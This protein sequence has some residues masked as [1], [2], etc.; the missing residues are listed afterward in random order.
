MKISAV[1]F[2]EVQEIAADAMF[3]A[4]MAFRRGKRAKAAEG[5]KAVLSTPCCGAYYPAARQMLERCKAKSIK[6][7]ARE[8]VEA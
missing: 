5:A 6:R 1:E 8:A 7:A 4:E 2:D 3:G